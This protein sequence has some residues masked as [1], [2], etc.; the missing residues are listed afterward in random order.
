MINR[1]EFDNPGI[2]CLK[3]SSESDSFQEKIYIG[4][5]ENIR[6]R[7]KQ[8]LKDAKKDFVEILFFISKDD[9]LTKTPIKYLE[10]RIVQLAIEAKNAEIE[11]GNSPSLPTLHEADKSDMEYFLEQMKLILPVMGFRFLISSVL[12]TVEKEETFQ[13]SE[14]V[15]FKINKS[16]IKANM[17]I[18]D[19]GFVVKKGSQGKKTLSKS[20]TETYRKLRAKLIDTEIMKVDGEFYVFLEDTV[21]SSP[22]AASNMVLGRNSNGYTEWVTDKGVTL[23]KMEEN[24]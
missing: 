24:N 9:L 22:S 17:F 14:K 5:A 8:H 19:Q 2:Y 20:C 12:K 23:R 11:N 16:D 4:E 13:A 3:S 10:S 7:I 21:F 18:T 6:A 15:I 1:D